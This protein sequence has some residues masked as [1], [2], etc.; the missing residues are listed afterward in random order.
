MSNFSIFVN[1]K[2]IGRLQKYHFHFCHK[3]KLTK[4]NDIPLIKFSVA[5][6][7]LPLSPLW[8]F[9]F[10]TYATD[11]K[12]FII[13]YNILNFKLKIGKKSSIHNSHKYYNF[14]KFSFNYAQ[15]NLKFILT[16]LKINKRKLEKLIYFFIKF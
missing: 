12:K 13:E 7:K 10:T 15:E 4:I 8:H 9:K 6:M 2:S 1:L 3:K 16:P 5:K 11:I 14:S